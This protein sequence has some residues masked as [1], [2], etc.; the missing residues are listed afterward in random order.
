MN[1]AISSSTAVKQND[2]PSPEITSAA[3]VCWIVFSAIALLIA[4]IAFRGVGRLYD[5]RSFYAAGFLLLHNPRHLFD[6]SLQESVQNAIVCPMWRGIP[7]Y[8]PAFEAILYVP[9]T[10]LAYRSAYFAYIILNLILFAACYLLAPSISDP[11][12]RKV[13][14]P[15]FFLLSFPALMCIVQGQDSVLF[16][17]LLCLIWR[18]LAKGNDLTAG[19][20]LALCLFKLQFVPLLVIFTAVFLPRRRAASLLQSFLPAAAALGALSIWLTGITGAAEWLRTLSSA[21]LASHLGHHAQ[22]IVAIVPGAMPSLNGLLYILGTRLL[23]PHVAYAVDAFAWVFVL[24][25]GLLSVARSATLSTAFSVAVAASLLLAPH[26]F[27]YDS[28]ALILAFFL[29]NGRPL[30][31]ITAF[32][33]LCPIMLCSINELRW[34]AFMA[35]VPL[36][37]LFSAWPAN[38][39]PL[40]LTPPEKSPPIG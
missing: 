25:A 29:L 11:T 37:I 27:F 12:L 33:Y 30:S 2:E 20:L 9:F 26:L 34:T 40:S 7:F 8:H 32:Y 15:V 19:V 16:L 21:A 31:F 5:F 39:I 4:A 18:S 3:I 36:T 24:A 23:S 6:L 35:L 14:R 10:F 38:H 28:L 1:T 22:S 17:F 13:P